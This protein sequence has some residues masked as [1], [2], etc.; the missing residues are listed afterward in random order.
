MKS[1]PRK[2]VIPVGG[3]GT[4]MQPATC[5]TPKEFLTVVDRPLIDYAYQEAVAA[6]INEI[7]FVTGANIILLQQYFSGNNPN[8]LHLT[9]VPQ[10]QPRGLGHAVLKAKSAVGDQPFAILLPDMLIDA[11]PCCLAQLL[12]LDAANAIAVE[13]VPQE[14]ISNYGI[15]LATPPGGKCSEV[16]GLVEKPKEGEVSSNL[17]IS[18]RYVFESAIFE[19]LKAQVVPE[20]GE[21]QL[22]DAIAKLMATRPIKALQYVGQSFDCGSREGL[23]LAGLHFGLKR[24]TIRSAIEGYLFKQSNLK[25]DLP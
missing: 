9:Y 25:G 21:L 10:E 17:A 3:R 8:G 16:T 6:E 22:T 24:P 12:A 14:S 18:G 5:V 2:L 4:R 15:V 23:V 11:T 19:C 7:I 20:G 1:R 13:Q